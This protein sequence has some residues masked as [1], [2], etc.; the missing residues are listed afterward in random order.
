MERREPFAERLRRVW[1]ESQGQFGFAATVD[2]KRIGVRY[3]ATAFVFFCLGGVEAL[4]LRAQL[5]RPQNDVLG[6]EQFDQLMTMHGTTMI[7]LFITPLLSGFGNYFVPL[8][9]GSRD[10]AFPRLNAFGYWVFVLSGIFLYWSF[11]ATAVPAGGWTSYFP[12]SGREYSTDLGLDFWSLGLIFLGIST[13]VGAVN[14]IVTIFKLR[15]P[16][17]TLARM[18]LFVWNILVTAFA[19][20]FAVPSL[21]TAAALLELDR[22]YNMRFFAADRGGDPLLWQ[23]LFWIFG[24]PDVYIIFMPAVGIVSM[25]IPVFARRPIVGYLLVAL[26]STATIVISFGVWVHHMFAVGLP[27][28]ALSFFSAASMLVSIPA[29]LQIL[30]WIATIWSGRPVWRTPFLFAASFLFLFVI[31]GLT[32]VM[33]A[34]VPFDWQVTDSY[35]VVAHFHYVLFGGAVFPV[36]AGLYYWLPKMTG[37][38]LDERLGQANFWLMFA[39]MN[40]AFFPMHIAGILG[41][42]RRVYTYPSGIG[43]DLPNQLSTFGA[44]LIGASV[45]VF[46][47]NWAWSVALERGAIAGADP[48]AANTLEWSVSS[49]PPAYNFAFIPTVRGRDPL[50]EQAR[51]ADEDEAARREPL[52]LALARKETPETSVLDADPQLLAR[53]PK[54]SLWPLSAALSLFIVFG[55]LLVPSA[56]IVALGALAL[57]ASVV[58]WLWPPAEGRLVELVRPTEGV[59]VPKA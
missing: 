1:E 40:L 56:P 43:L 15:A 3:I 14:F 19:M 27:P 59:W 6:P 28:V 44:Y 21:T 7:F 52:E 41:M 23:H 47:A 5:V 54:E 29:G 46:I 34:S 11:L 57:I 50:W 39:G 49:P 45:V 35:F 38:I 13:T 58:G 36:F 32:G 30:A 12:L 17:M 53:M 31:G 9:I 33:V 55:G 22:M 4:T 10:M 25:V 16:G 42:P 2:H 51:V 48:W 26:A 8:L 37:R 18:P 20:L 24:H